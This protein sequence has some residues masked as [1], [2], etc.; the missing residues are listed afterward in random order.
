VDRAT[1]LGLR[2]ED[3]ANAIEML[4]NN[5]WGGAFDIVVIQLFE[6][7][8]EIDDDFLRFARE[9]GDGMK[10]ERR[11]YDFLEKLVTKN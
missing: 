11:K 9:I 10:L 2:P 7:G 1:V 4:D 3:R 8:I 6:Y 5:E